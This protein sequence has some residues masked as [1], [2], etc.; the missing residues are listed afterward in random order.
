[1]SE[2]LACSA[3]VLVFGALW[4][5]IYK[6][7]GLDWTTDASLYGAHRQLADAHLALDGEMH[8]ATARLSP[9]SSSRSSD[10]PQPSLFDVLAAHARLSMPG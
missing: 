4:L 9:A 8:G 1:M 3:A 2:I 10:R 7:G 5:A 6:F